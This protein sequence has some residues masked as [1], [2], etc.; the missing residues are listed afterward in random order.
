MFLNAQIDG[1][2]IVCCVWS[3]TCENE[4]WHAYSQWSLNGSIFGLMLML[5]G[6]EWKYV[7]DDAHY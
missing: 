5:H 1:T 4:L 3:K 2:K 6:F 7:C